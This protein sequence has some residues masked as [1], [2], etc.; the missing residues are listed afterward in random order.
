MRHATG[1]RVK[2]REI[3]GTRVREWT[4]KWTKPAVAGG[5]QQ[6]QRPPSFLIL[7]S[8]LVVQ[9]AEEIVQVGLLV[10]SPATQDRLSISF[11][12]EYYYSVE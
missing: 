10:A 8:K 7:G 12:R 11:G 2:R 4:V 1:Q 3:Y 5:G 6:P 9:L